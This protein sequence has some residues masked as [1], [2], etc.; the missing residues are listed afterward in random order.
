MLWCIDQTLEIEFGS[1]SGIL[2]YLTNGDALNIFGMA[3][4]LQQEI[5]NIKNMMNYENQNYVMFCN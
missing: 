4:S 5:W 1:L 3:I 2:I